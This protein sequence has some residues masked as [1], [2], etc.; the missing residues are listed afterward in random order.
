METKDGSFQA[1]LPWNLPID[2]PSR[3]LDAATVLT[4][5][6]IATHSTA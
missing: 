4:P 6:P 2:Q 5:E 3:G 1:A